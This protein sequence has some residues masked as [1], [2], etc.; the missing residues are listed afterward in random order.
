MPSEMAIASHIHRMIDHTLL[1]PV[2]TNEMIRNLCQEARQYD[3]IAV[4]VHPHYVPLAARELADTDV[5]VCTVIGFPLGL[6]SCGVKLKEA[7][8]AVEKGALELDL[9]TNMAH[10]KNGEWQKVEEEMTA[11][12]RLKEEAKGPLVVKGILETCYLTN[13]ELI[14]LCQFAAACGLDFV[15]TSTGFGPSGATIEHVALMRHTV[16]VQIGVKASGGIRSYADAVRMIEAGASRI[17]TSSGVQI[18]QQAKM[19]IV[20]QAGQ[21]NGEWLKEGRS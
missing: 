15:K 2:A 1:H 11:F 20:R 9:V 21:T 6:H 16:G 13:E 12:C 4:C 5:R 19:V 7:D 8:E 17:G 18:V 3:F 14:R 10:V